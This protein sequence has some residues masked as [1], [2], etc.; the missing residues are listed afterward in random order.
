MYDTNVV[1]T[2]FMHLLSMLQVLMVPVLQRVTRL[3][4]S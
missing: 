3:K 1:V 2:E 4:I